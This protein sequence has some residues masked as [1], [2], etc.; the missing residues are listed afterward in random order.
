MTLQFP[1]NQKNQ[2]PEIVRNES[3]REAARGELVAVPSYTGLN[4]EGSLKHSEL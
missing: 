2:L 4:T 1:K 3:F